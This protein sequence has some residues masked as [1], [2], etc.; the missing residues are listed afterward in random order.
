ME[1]GPWGGECL[2]YSYYEC[3]NEQSSE[4]AIVEREECRNEIGSISTL[5]CEYCTTDH[6]NT[7]L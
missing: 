1:A 7:S 2:T 5:I 4:K 6:C 3:G